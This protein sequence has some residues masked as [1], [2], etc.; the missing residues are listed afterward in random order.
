MGLLRLQNTIITAYSYDPS[1]G[2]TTGIILQSDEAEMKTIKEQ[3]L[4]HKSLIGHKLLFQTIITEMSLKVWKEQTSEIKQDVM[5]IEHS[6]GQHTWD[7]YIARDAKP[8]PDVELSRVVHGLKI[9]AAVV[10]RRIEAVSIWTEL[11]LESLVEDQEETATGTSMLQWVRNL[12]TQVRMAKLDVELV[13]KRVDN[14]VG[15]VSLAHLSFGLHT[16]RLAPE[17]ALKYFRSTTD[18]RNEITS[19]RRRYPRPPT[20]IRPP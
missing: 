8:K 13:T 16:T 15:A 6:T 20:A 1:D 2:T 19:R 11:L 5:D 7:D 4:F 3:I 17:Y 18:S 14:Q 9:Q 10:Y 12:K